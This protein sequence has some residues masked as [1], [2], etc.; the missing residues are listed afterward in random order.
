MTALVAAPIAIGSFFLLPPIAFFL[1]SAVFLELVVL[2]YIKVLRPLAPGAPLNCLAILVIP[3]AAAFAAVITGVYS[4]SG[5]FLVLVLGVLASVV[6]GMV[7]LLGKTPLPEVVPAL[8]ILGFGLPY[9]SLPLAGLYVLQR[10]DPWLLILA[11]GIIWVGDAAA[12]Y[13]GTAFGRH[14][15]TPVVS[16]KK[17]WEG[18]L[19]GIVTGVVATAIWCWWRLGEI[20]PWFLVVGAA[21]AV[22][23]VLGDLMESLFK[24]STGVKDSGSFLPGHGGFYDRLDATLFGIPVLL[25]GLHWIGFPLGL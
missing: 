11:F 21:T 16:P 1:F 20:D 18:T 8:G 9:F 17:S 5:G 4:P 22:A 13:F 25:L 24:R 7:V 10:H 6:L 23:A 19:A 15:M 2:E 14:K 12:Y 3:V